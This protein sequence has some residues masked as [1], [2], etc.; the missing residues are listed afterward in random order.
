METGASEEK[1]G[2]DRKTGRKGERQRDKKR[3]MGAGWG[4]FKREHRRCS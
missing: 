1:V 3:E 2:G 4:P